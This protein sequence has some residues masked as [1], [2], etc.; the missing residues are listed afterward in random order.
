MLTNAPVDGP[1]VL[2]GFSIGGL[3]ARL[4]ANTWPKDVAG[5]VLVDHAFIEP[6][7]T[8]NPRVQSESSD[9]ILSVQQVDTPPTLISAAPIALGIEDDRNFKKLPELNRR[10]HAWA[11]SDNPVRPTLQTAAECID[12][13]SAATGDRVSPLGN[14]P[15]IVVSTLNESPKYGELQQKLLSLSR[16]SRQILAE[17]ST[18]MVIV[19]EPDVII[20]AIRQVVG[21]VRN[22]SA[23]RK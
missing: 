19:D 10:L 8:A 12:E 18:H 23:L 16:N 1:Y 11:M 3:Y 20:G 9:G 15:L 22:H 13:V 4:Y 7:G 17:N 14:I 5:M 6:S 2:V 21:A